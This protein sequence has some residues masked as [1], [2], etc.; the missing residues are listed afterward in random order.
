MTPKQKRKAKYNSLL[1]KIKRWATKE[2]GPF[3]YKHFIIA[4][5]IMVLFLS[6]V[7]CARPGHEKEIPIRSCSEQNVQITGPCSHLSGFT[8]HLAQIK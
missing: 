3:E 8:Q 7:G 5:A 6:L 4:A 1:N 2:D